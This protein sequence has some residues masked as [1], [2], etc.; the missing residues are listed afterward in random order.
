MTKTGYI[1]NSCYFTYKFSLK[2]NIPKMV[3]KMEYTG[4]EVAYYQVFFWCC[5]KIIAFLLLIVI[6]FMVGSVT[7][8]MVGITFM[9]FI[10]FIQKSM[11]VHFVQGVCMHVLFS[12]VFFC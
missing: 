10:T 8:F 6:T 4:P 11:V 9:V 1:T 2:K 7:T 12:P 3:L 5:A